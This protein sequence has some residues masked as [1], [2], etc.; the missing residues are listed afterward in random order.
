MAGTA[1]YNPGPSPAFRGGSTRAERLAQP[2]QKARRNLSNAFKPAF[3]SHVAR[4]LAGRCHALASPL[5]LRRQIVNPAHRLNS[6]ANS[7]RRG[8]VN[9]LGDVRGAGQA[10]RESRSYVCG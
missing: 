7:I 8:L 6:K 3:S 9:S 5:S 2:F 4:A 10:V 1:P